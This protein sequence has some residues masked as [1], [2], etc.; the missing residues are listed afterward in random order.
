MDA[1]TKDRLMDEFR[2]CLDDW[3]PDDGTSA[4]PQENEPPVNLALLFTELAVLR[5]EVRVEACQFKTALDEMRS[6]TELLGK[7]NQRLAQELERSREAQGAAL[8]QAE[9]RLLLEVL[10]VRDRIAAAV[11]VSDAYEPGFLA[12]FA[13]KETQLTQGL[14]AGIALTLRRIDDL[15]AERRVRPLEAVGGRLDPHTMR[16][17]GVEWLAQR[18]P[19]EVISE[20]RRG[21]T[22]DDEMLRLAEVIVNKKEI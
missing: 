6:L 14:S 20:V 8:R 17:V 9:T 15:L 16:A 12:R 4:K 21:Y 19:G 22:R 1:E 3:E 2:A 18:P 13:R 5:N 11:S 7:H 10:D